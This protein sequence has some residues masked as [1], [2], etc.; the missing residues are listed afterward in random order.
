MTTASEFFERLANVGHDPSLCKVSGTVRFDI[1]SGEQ[2]Q[3]WL[4]HID[5]GRLRV[6]QDGGP[7]GTVIVLSEK[8]AEAMA[9]GELNGLAAMLRGEIMVDGDLGLALRLGRL[10]PSSPAL[11]GPVSGP[12]TRGV[13]G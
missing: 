11:R 3:R 9:R 5:H 1:R 12:G 6:L 2:V 4:L 10:F 8:V 7:A 13:T